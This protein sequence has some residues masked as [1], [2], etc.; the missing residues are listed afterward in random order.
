MDNFPNLYTYAKLVV[1]LGSPRGREH[2]VQD[3]G[4]RIE[5]RAKR[6]DYKE[7]GGENDVIYET[8]ETVKFGWVLWWVGNWMILVLG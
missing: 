5:P 7:G 1:Q 3:F 8:L 6:E 4:V 2:F